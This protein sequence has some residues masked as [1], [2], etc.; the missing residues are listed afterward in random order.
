MDVDL[1]VGTGLSGDALSGVSFETRDAL[2][3]SPV[4]VFRERGVLPANALEFELVDKGTRIARLG[5]GLFEARVPQAGD[6]P[7]TLR[8]GADGFW[9]CERV[10]EFRSGAE[11]TEFDYEVPEGRR[12]V[13]DLADASRAARS[14]STAPCFSEYAAWAHVARIV[15]APSGEWVDASATEPGTPPV[16]LLGGRNGQQEAVLWLPAAADSIAFGYRDPCGVRPVSPG[17]EVRYWAPPA[18]AAPRVR[19]PPSTSRGSHVVVSVR[20]DG[21]ALRM[22]GIPITIGRSPRPGEPAGLAGSRKNFGTNA[23]GVAEVWLL[24]GRYRIGLDAA[25]AARGIAVT[26]DVADSDAAIP[27]ALEFEF[28]R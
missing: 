5:P 25:A 6:Y 1:D 10:V 26:V 23:D 24:P 8:I 21:E 4:P 15:P 27:V 9:L 20:R 3:G 17:V 16:S 28:P 7:V 22:R 19:V 11:P 12:V 14:R 2:S 18:M 13:L